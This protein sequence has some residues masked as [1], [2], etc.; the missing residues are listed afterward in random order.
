MV[1][2][3]CPMCTQLGA[4]FQQSKPDERC[5]SLWPAE[6]IY[7]VCGPSGQW[8]ALEELCRLLNGPKG[9]PRISYGSDGCGPMPPHDNGYKPMRLSVLVMTRICDCGL[10]WP[11]CSFF[12]FLDCML[13]AVMCG[14]I[15]NA[16]YCSNRALEV[17]DL[18]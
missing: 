7:I 17:L 12:G 8:P 18:C 4:N 16:Q 3:K 13:T 10:P 6:N 2:C 5:G 9:K 14:E 1:E 15:R 11:L